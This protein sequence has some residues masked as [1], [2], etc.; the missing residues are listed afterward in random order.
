MARIRI[1]DLKADF[2]DAFPGGTQ[3]VPRPLHFQP[4]EILGRRTPSGSFEHAAEME[5]AHISLVSEP[6]QAKV[7]RHICGHQ[8]GDLA[9][10]KPGQTQPP[11][12]VAH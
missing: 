9:S 11:F 12:A 6:G 5:F 1:S 4:D 2:D 10:F 8:L 7:R 3:Q